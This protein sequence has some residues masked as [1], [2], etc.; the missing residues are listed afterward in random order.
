[1]EKVYFT[2]FCKT[3]N[4]T[5]VDLQELQKKYPASSFLNL[6]ALNSSNFSLKKKQKTK[7][8]LSIY[9]FD[10]LDSYVFDV[11][12]VTFYR[13]KPNINIVEQKQHSTY[14]LNPIFVKQP[15]S[16][17]GNRQA[18]IDQLIKKFSKDAPKIIYSPDLHD[19]EA[20]YGEDS[21]KEDLSIVSV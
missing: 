3:K 2:D 4:G 6:F 5:R 8:L 1:M 16:D 17:S 20:D 15:L 18:L 21:S 12:P 7:I 14:E 11:E 9:N 10:I 13:E 19:A